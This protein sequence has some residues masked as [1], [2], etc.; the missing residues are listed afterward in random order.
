MIYLLAAIAV[1]C[2]IIFTFKVAHVKGWNG[3]NITLINYACAAVLTSIICLFAGQIGAFREIVNIDFSTLTTQQTVGNTM[4]FVLAG[5][6]LTGI[7]YL[8]NIRCINPSVKSNGA[9]IS[10]LFNRSGFLITITLSMLLWGEE[11]NWRRWLGVG[12]TIAALAMAAIPGKGNKLEVPRPGLLIAMTLCLGVLETNN[13]VFSMYALQEYKSNF[14]MVTFI[15]ALTL[16]II[17]LLMGNRKRGIKLKITWQEFAAGIVLGVPN[18]FGN[19]FQIMALQ[20]IP[21]SVLFPSMAAGNLLI[22]TLL[23]RFVFKEKLGY[24]QFLAVGFTC[25]SLI[26]INL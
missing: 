8:V 3:D 5:G 1:S 26:L 17:T 6:T 7:L 14:A 9:G 4:F 15:V 12:L 22:S 11:M 2:I 13:K 24:R 25:F 20:T 21:V 16:C 23:S 19:I 10:T 18:S